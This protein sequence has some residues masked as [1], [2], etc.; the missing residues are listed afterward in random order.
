MASVEHGARRP[1]FRMIAVCSAALLLLMSSFQAS[2]GQGGNGD[3][4][5]D[6]GLSG[7]EIAAIA[8]GGAAGLYGLWLLAGADDDDDDEATEAASTGVPSGG[9]ATAARLVSPD[10]A[11]LAAGDAAVFELEVRRNGRW[12]KVSGHP[13]ASFATSGTLELADGAKNLVLAPLGAGSGHGKVLATYRTSNG[14]LLTAEA[15]VQ[16]GGQ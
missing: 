15:A 6:G 14:Q 9:D 13:A 4:D 12:E 2:W 5:D 10:G 7:G 11:R 1:L 3:Y 16:V 8:I